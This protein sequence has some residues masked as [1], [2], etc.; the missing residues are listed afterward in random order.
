MSKVISH[1][2]RDVQAAGAATAQPL[3]PSFVALKAN[4]IQFRLHIPK[5]TPVLRQVKDTVAHGIRNCDKQQ[6]RPMLPGSAL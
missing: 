6:Y 4:G 5:E 3:G 1:L 2:L